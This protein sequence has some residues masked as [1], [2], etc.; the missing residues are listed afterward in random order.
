MK[1]VLILSL[2]AAA[3]VCAPALAA[4]S[5]SPAPQLQ[6]LDVSVGRWVYHG[7]TRKTR[8][9]KPGTW[10]WNEDCRWSPDHVFLECSFTNDWSGKVVKSLVVDTYNSQDRTYWHYELFAAGASGKHPFVSRMSIQGNTWTE[11]G[12]DAVRGKKVGE[13][14]IYHFTSPTRASV[15]IQTSTD[16][17]HWTTQDQGEGQKQP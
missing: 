11:F 6:K 8:S 13:R 5:H 3:L 2:F 9:G 1:P 12:Q 7:T 15:A 14:I 4:A 16:G 17:I 10:T